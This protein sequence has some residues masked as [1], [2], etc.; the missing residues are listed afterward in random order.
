M[1]SIEVEAAV[2]AEGLRDTAN[3]KFRTPTHTHKH[4][5]SMLSAKWDVR[6]HGKDMDGPETHPSVSFQSESS[7]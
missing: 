7:Y 5:E 3:V 1:E 2:K 6:K 4:R